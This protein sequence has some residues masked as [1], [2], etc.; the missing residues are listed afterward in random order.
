[1]QAAPRLRTLI[2]GGGAA[3]AVEQGIRPGE[4][5]GSVDVLA[6]S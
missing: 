6:G 2:V 4:E 5:V 3:L 1:M